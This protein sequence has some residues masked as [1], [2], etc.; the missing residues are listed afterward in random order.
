[1]TDETWA[2]WAAVLD[3]LETDVALAE[4]LAHDPSGPSPEPWEQPT[5]DAPLPLGL[6][7]RAHDVL[8][9]QNQVRAALASALSATHRQQDFASRVDRATRLAEPSIYV[10]VSA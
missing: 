7:D 2:V 10:D 1:M 4:Q 8:A 3:R 5:L 9:R 6:V